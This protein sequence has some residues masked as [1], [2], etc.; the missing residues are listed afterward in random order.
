MRPLI[1]LVDHVA[2]ALQYH[3]HWYGVMR[4]RAI[5]RNP[6]LFAAVQLPSPTPISGAGT[7]AGIS[8]SGAKKEEEEKVFV[9]AGLGGEVSLAED[10]EA[11]LHSE[12]R[13]LESARCIAIMHEFQSASVDAAVAARTSLSS[14]HILHPACFLGDL[15]CLGYGRHL[16]FQRQRSGGGDAPL[17]GKRKESSAAADAAAGGGA[18]GGGAAGG[19]GSTGAGREAP[20]SSHATHSTPRVPALPA[21]IELGVP[22]S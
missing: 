16:A 2:E 12:Q 7:D 5:A 21:G 11:T 4:N 17:R 3:L 9:S 10:I 15:R 19:G 14:L 18:A 1:R 22:L 6:A 8:T 13:A 20:S